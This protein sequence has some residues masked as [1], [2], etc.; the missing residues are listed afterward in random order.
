MTR[1]RVR[2]SLAQTITEP[3][4]NCGGRGIVLTPQILACDLL[5]QLAAEAR[6]FPGYHLNL[7]AHPQVTAMVEKDGARLLTRLAQEHQVQVTVTPQPQFARD[8]FEISREW[9]GDE[10]QGSAVG[11]SG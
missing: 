1:Q 4:G 7:S 5:R 11:M 9:P 6:E 10:V 2:D 3:C 8:H